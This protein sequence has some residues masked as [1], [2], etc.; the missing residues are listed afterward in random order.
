MWPWSWEDDGCA[1][2]EGQ[3]Q[4]SQGDLRLLSLYLELAELPHS[5][6]HLYLFPPQPPTDAITAP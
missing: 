4:Q 1:V 2:E 6:Q 3:I 5:I